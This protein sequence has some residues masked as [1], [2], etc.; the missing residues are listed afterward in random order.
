MKKFVVL[1]ISVFLVGILFT[2]SASA[3]TCPYDPTYFIVES[4]ILSLLTIPDEAKVFLPNLLGLAHAQTC[5]TTIDYWTKVKVRNHLRCYLRELRA[6][7]ATSSADK[8]T[9]TE[10]LDELLGP[11]YPIV[12]GDHVSRIGTPPPKL[13]PPEDL[14]A[15]KIYVVGCL[16]WVPVQGRIVCINGHALD[17]WAYCS[18]DS[19]THSWEYHPMDLVEPSGALAAPST[20]RDTT[21]ISDGEASVFFGDVPGSYKIKVTHTRPDEVVTTSSVEVIV[22]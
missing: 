16:G 20:R 3:Q 1:L 2:P 4:I 14:T 22:Q 18:P 13:T 21:L 6:L 8:T 11:T 12:L 5:F 17:L 10:I 19:G 15:C 7:S 9:I